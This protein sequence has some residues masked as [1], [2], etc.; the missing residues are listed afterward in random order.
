M[1]SLTEPLSTD[2]L[3]EHDGV[4]YCADTTIR[5]MTDGAWETCYPYNGMNI[6]SLAWFGDTCYALGYSVDSTGEVPYQ[7]LVLEASESG[8]VS[9]GEPIS[10]SL[11]HS[12]TSE[13]C[14]CIS[15]A[16]DETSAFFLLHDPDV[17]LSQT[18]TLYQVSLATG[19]TT[20]LSTGDYAHLALCQGILYMDV[21][22][23]AHLSSTLMAY[24][25]QTDVWT[26]IE[27][28]QRYT[29]AAPVY[30]PE[31]DTI[32]Y[33]GGSDIKRY[34][35]ATGTATVVCPSEIIVGAEDGVA[36]LGNFYVAYCRPTAWGE[37]AYTQVK[38]RGQTHTIAVNCG[39]GDPFVLAYRRMHP[40]ISF[41]FET[42]LA[43]DYAQRVVAQEP[44]PH[45]YQ[46][47][48]LD[49][50]FDFLLDKG[51]LTPLD[52]CEEISTFV[53]SLYPVL[54]ESLMDEE[55]RIC[56]MPATLNMAAG[57]SYSPQALADAGF[58]VDD[59][60]TTML[61][62]TAF[63][64][65]WQVR[66]NEGEVSE[67]LFGR[68]IS[69]RI[70]DYL[71]STA[72]DTQLSTQRRDGEP[73]KL[74]TPELM[75]V[76]EW[77]DEHRS[78]SELQCTLEDWEVTPLFQF[79]LGDLSPLRDYTWQDGYQ[80]ML[81][82]MDGNHEPILPVEM[83]L[84]AVNRFSAEEDQAAAKAFLNSMPQLMQ[85]LQRVLM[86]PE[87]NEPILD[88]D[89]AESLAAG[90]EHLAE[91][92][93]VAAEV[94]GVLSASLQESIDLAELLIADA[95]AD[96]YVI[97]AEQIAVWREIAPSMYVV[98]G[99]WNSYTSTKQVYEKFSKGQVSAEQFL[100]ELER[101]MQMEALENE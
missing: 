47:Q 10:L 31:T 94:E 54:R 3:V 14:S 18:C 22:D 8:L 21:M 53:E 34:D 11:F 61:E 74:C 90:Q 79:D 63:I 92:L 6:C 52:D 9:A 86:Q 30:D 56:A 87:Q 2:C 75:Q 60:P 51:Y 67:L 73:L 28:L 1:E 72:I 45:V 98:T 97:N 4:L 85:P 80:P 96:L 19:E 41:R 70:W 27:P 81:M 65:E 7:L 64:D 20:A 39:Q 25:P 32:Y 12:A 23:A 24:D 48:Q 37:P 36:L 95:Q 82:A 84:Y 5:T 55:G 26:E 40:E 38:H 46:F 50:N 91:L 58:T 29:F 43:R 66:A 49:G 88:E 59:L 93:A 57:F 69:A 83:S 77:L 44:T 16:V 71:L 15:L 78:L 89:A 99:T 100:Q 76:V 17:N 13:L 68:S 101:I 42:I 35:P 62:M 33:T